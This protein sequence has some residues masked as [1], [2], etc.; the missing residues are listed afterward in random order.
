[1][2]VYTL[3][4]P[5]KNKP[6]GALK[7]AIPWSPSYTKILQDLVVINAAFSSTPLSFPNGATIIRWLLALHTVMDSYK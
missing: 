5:G 1:M 2:I 3:E 4:S 6:G 7:L